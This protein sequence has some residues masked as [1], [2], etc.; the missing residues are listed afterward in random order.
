MTMA[1]SSFGRQFAVKKEKAGE[2]VKEMSKK[3]PPTLQSDFHSNFASE[4]DLRESLSK[5]LNSRLPG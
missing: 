3:V 4:N 5:A 2:F 1:I